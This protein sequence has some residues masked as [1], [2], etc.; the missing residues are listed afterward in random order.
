MDTVPLLRRGPHG[1]CYSRHLVLYYGGEFMEREDG[2]WQCR[3][4]QK[5][6]IIAMTQE[7]LTEIF[8]RLPIPQHAASYLHGFSVRLHIVSLNPRTRLTQYLCGAR[9]LIFQCKVTLFPLSVMNRDQSHGLFLRS[10]TDVA[11]SSFISILSR[12]LI[13]IRSQT[14][15]C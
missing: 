7:L 15:I 12:Y 10:G 5:H 14:L 4:F 11:L 8:L 2:A 9:S 1:Q 6:Y 3:L 13:R